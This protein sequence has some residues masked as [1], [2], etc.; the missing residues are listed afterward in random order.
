MAI[1]NNNAWQS[2]L[3]ECFQGDDCLF[4]V[5]CTCC[6]YGQ[7]KSML[8]TNQVGG[9]D[10]CA[11]CN[12]II[13]AGCCGPLG[14]LCTN[15]NTRQEIRKRYG[16]VGEE[17]D[18]FYSLCCSGLE[19]IQQ[20]KELKARLTGQVGSQA[21]GQSVVYAQAA[22]PQVVYAQA[23]PQV[24]YAQAQPQVVYATQR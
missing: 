20:K 3:F 17:P 9:T 1:P 14:M 24:V 16:L 10:T 13:C 18:C 2:G 11:A 8:K 5:L 12:W 7:V 21:G 23:Q 15:L 22:Q 19:I 4:N 6:V